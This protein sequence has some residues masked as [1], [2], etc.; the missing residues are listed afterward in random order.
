MP[1]LEKPCPRILARPAEA[2]ARINAL[3]QSQGIALLPAGTTGS[4]ALVL[5]ER[6]RQLFSE[7]HR[8]NDM[9]RHNIAFPQG[10]N[11]KGQAYGPITCMPLPDQVRQNNPNVPSR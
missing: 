4:L 9:L 7:G 10:A 3:R 6:K 5:E 11:H 8:L 1:V 2:V